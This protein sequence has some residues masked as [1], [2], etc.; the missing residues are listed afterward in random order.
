MAT[1]ITDVSISGIEDFDVLKKSLSDLG[2]VNDVEVA[3]VSLARNKEAL[4]V[5]G[6]D[7]S[8]ATQQEISD[9]ASQYV[10]AENLSQAI[11]YLTYQKMLNAMVDMD[12]TE[13]VSNLLVLAKNAGITGEAISHLTE[14]EI[15]YQ[16]I[17]IQQ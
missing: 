6:L 10:S 11:Q 4:L 13:E 7:L 14:L 2:V 9:F 5:A 12:T 8:T 17:E 1:A 3:F 15:L 16:E